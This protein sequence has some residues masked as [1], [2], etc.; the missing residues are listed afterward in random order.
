MNFDYVRVYLEVRAFQQQN[1]FARNAKGQ[2][3][4]SFFSIHFKRKMNLMGKAL[5]ANFRFSTNNAAFRFRRKEQTFCFKKDKNRKLPNF[6][7]QKGK[8]GKNC[9]QKQEV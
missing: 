3:G 7:P 9:L 4:L 5:M 1:I 8:I 6:S 2:H